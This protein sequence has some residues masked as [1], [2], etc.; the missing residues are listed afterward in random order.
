MSSPAPASPVRIRPLRAILAYVL[1]CLA[2]THILTFWMIV[3]GVVDAP[4]APASSVRLFEALLYYLSS[5]LLF[6]L[7]AAIFTFIP[8]LIVRF[9]LLAFGL[10]SRWAAAIGGLAVG[11]LVAV[12]VGGLGADN[13]R[14]VFEALTASEGLVISFTLT[15]V[16][17]GLIWHLVEFGRRRS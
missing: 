13:L 2:A 17:C 8:A 12:V 7:L 16:C 11:F 15:G 10:T 4:D 6:G 1:T 3:F 14:E 5:T 9:I